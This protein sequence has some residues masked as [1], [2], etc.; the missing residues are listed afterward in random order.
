MPV[1]HS[2]VIDCVKIKFN[3][4]SSTNSNK[5]LSKRAIVKSCFEVQA[6]EIFLILIKIRVK[7]RAA[8]Y[9]LSDILFYFPN[10]IYNFQDQL[11]FQREAE[12]RKGFAKEGYVYKIL[13]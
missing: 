13:I 3:Y 12:D 10:H 5:K 7:A 9:V 11:C 1:V 6:I 2:P 8:L 4:F